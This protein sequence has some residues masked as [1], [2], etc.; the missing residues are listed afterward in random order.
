MFAFAFARA[1]LPDLHMLAQHWMYCSN[2]H[3]LSRACA[4]PLYPAGDGRVHTCLRFNRDKISDRCAKEEN[5]LAAIEYRD[6]R[7]RPKLNKL[8]SEEKAVY[9]SVGG[10]GAPCVLVAPHRRALCASGAPIIA[11]LHRIEAVQG[12][13][14]EG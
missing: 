6:I 7:L 3:L 11:T 1:R 5:K 9:C 12:A 10:A 2:F 14:A 8:C 13:P 4:P